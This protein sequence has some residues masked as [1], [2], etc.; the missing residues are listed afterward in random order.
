MVEV[1]GQALGMEPNFSE[2]PGLT[3]A[4]SQRSSRAATKQPLLISIR[5]ADS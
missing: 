2:E 1:G 3:Q 4:A 5:I